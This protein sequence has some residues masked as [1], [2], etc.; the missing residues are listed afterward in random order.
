[1]PQYIDS[2][3]LVYNR[4]LD[5]VNDFFKKYFPAGGKELAADYP[6]PEFSD[7]P[8]VTFYSAKELLLHLEK[9]PNFEYTIYFQ[10]NNQLSEI[11][12]ITLQYT[13]DGNIIFG[14]SIIGDDL[15]TAS[16]IQI[17]KQVK[18][19]LHSDIAC[20]TM[21]EPPPINSDEFIIFCNERFIPK[22]D[23]F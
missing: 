12:Q 3:Y 18:K 23:D 4:K 7:Y 20:I 15:S 2:Y 11:K 17:F 8:D 21:E 13:D 14:I 6:F 1:M 5:V 10:N 22:F 16:S 9:M 19:Y